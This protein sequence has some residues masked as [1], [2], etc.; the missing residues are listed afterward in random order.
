MFVC[1]LCLFAG[2]V[3]AAFSS[4]NSIEKNSSEDCLHVMIARVPYERI[5][6]KIEGEKE[7]K[8]P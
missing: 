1:W 5:H 8:E 3:F 7:T 6:G 2:N 4:K